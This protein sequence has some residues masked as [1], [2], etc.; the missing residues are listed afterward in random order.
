MDPLVSYLNKAIRIDV[1]GNIHFENQE[2]LSSYFFILD[3]GIS[4]QTEPLVK[5]FKETYQKDHSFF[6]AI[7]KLKF[8]NQKSID[9]ILVQDYS[10]LWLEMCNIS[11]IQYNYMQ[12]M[13]PEIYHSLWKQGL[14]SDY[15]RLKLCGAGGGGMLMG[16]T[17]NKEKLIQRFQNYSITFI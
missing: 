16:I 8:H 11:D 5:Y 9:A 3:T 12:K 4:R 2:E 14:D 6:L 10:T 1:S 7:E 13:I 15:F 17:L